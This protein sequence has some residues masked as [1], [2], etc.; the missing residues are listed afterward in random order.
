MKSRRRCRGKERGIKRE[1]HCQ[2]SDS[3]GMKRAGRTSTRVT[4][5]VLLLVLR[6]SYDVCKSSTSKFPSSV[7]FF[8]F[9]FVRSSC[10]PCRRRRRRHRRRVLVQL[11]AHLPLSFRVFIWKFYVSRRNKVSN[12]QLSDCGFC[13]YRLMA[14]SAIT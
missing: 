14:K 11:D 2:S 6:S 9:F 13:R 8:S 5:R 10:L 12:W 4:K 7:P 3:E 1:L